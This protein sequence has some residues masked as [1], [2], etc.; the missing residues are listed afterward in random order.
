MSGEEHVDPAGARM[1]ARR[2]PGVDLERLSLVQRHSGPMIVMVYVGPIDVLLELGLLDPAMVP[3][4]RKRKAAGSAFEW[5]TWRLRGGRLEVTRWLTQESDVPPALEPF[6]PECW[7]LAETA[8]EVRELI[9]AEVRYAL[10]TWAAIAKTLR[11]SVAARARSEHRGY[12]VALEDA[13]R[14][15]NALAGLDA[16]LD[17]VRAPLRVEPIERPMLRVINGGR[18]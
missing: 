17:E 1:F 16:L 11:E 2:F 9:E 14:I 7:P 4:G 8:A 13:A 3:P 5:S 12:R 15:E 18:A 10:D 6:A